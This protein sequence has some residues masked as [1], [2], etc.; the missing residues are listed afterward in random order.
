[1]R[2]VCAALL[3]LGLLCRASAPWAQ[4]PLDERLDALLAGPAL[5]DAR[6]AALVVRD[7]DAKVVFAR[8]PDQ[9]MVPA[10]NMKILTALAVLDAFGPTHRF[11]T[12]VL[13]DRAPDAEGRVGQLVLRG[14]GDP[15]MNTEDWLR[16]ASELRRTGLRGVEGDLVVDDSAFDQEYWHPS[17]GRV[18]ARA[19]HAPVGALTANYGAY[20]VTVQP[21][22]RAGDPVRV[23]ID[24]PVSYLRLSNLAVTGAANARRSLVVDRLSRE[25]ESERVR[26]TG[27]VRAGDEADSFPRSV[28][29]PAL[30]AGA[31]ARLQLEGQGIPIGGRVRRGDASGPRHTLLRF[32]GRPLAEVVTLFMKYSNNG[33]A[34]SLVKSLGAHASGQPGSWETGLAELR[35]RLEEA[36]LPVTGLVLADGSGLSTDDRAT[37]RLLVEALRHGRRSF[38]FGPE[39]MASLPIAGRDG[40]LERRAGQAAG[41]VRAKTGLLSD[42]GVTALSGY[43]R[44]PDGELLVFA[45]VVN[46]FRRGSQVAMD[47]VD[48][49][50]TELVGR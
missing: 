11:T 6:V 21:G 38:D 13:A 4:P 49:W 47:A 46:G 43:A 1:M 8:A 2:H 19:Y 18:S 48:G 44:Q 7:R 30:Y 42:A 20:F 26:V 27:V 29:D 34:E 10:S 23:E 32:E 3:A 39:L 41:E 16:L 36:R 35:R 50:V 31:V 45:I 24:P 40:T 9:A 22:R 33:I 17:W 15:V 14:G 28:L 37:P 5:A 12:E 25:G